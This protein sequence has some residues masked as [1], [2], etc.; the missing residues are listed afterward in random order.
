MGLLL[1]AMSCSLLG[2]GGTAMQRFTKT[3]FPG[4]FSMVIAV[5]SFSLS[6]PAEATPASGAQLDAQKYPVLSQSDVAVLKGVLWTTASRD[7]K[8]AFVWGV[9]S[10]IEVE[11]IAMERIPELKVRNVSAVAAEGL[12]NVSLNDI[13]RAVDEYYKANPANLDVP[14]LRILWDT[15][16]APRV[17]TGVAGRPLQH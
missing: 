6:V 12:K 9:C 7:S 1:S 3:C 16:I 15:M 4:I 8:V 14:V 10:M 17:T 11:R 13:V 5:L 2:E